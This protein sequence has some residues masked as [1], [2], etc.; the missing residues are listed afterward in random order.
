MIKPINLK[1]KP[2]LIAAII[3]IVCAIIYLFRLEAIGWYYWHAYKH[4]DAARNYSLDLQHYQ[5]EIDGVP[6]EALED[7]SGLTYNASR[8]SLFTVLNQEPLIIEVSVEGK[9]LRKIQVTGADDMEGIT[10][11]VD[12]RYVIA[13]EKDNRLVLV[14]IDDDATHVDLNDAPKL[15]LGINPSSNKNFEGVSWDGRNKRLLVTKERDPKYVMSVKGFF[16]ADIGEPLNIEISKVH[17]FDAAIKWSLR[18][19]S[20]LTYHDSSGHLFLLSDESRL[21]KEYDSKGRAVGALALWKGFHGLNRHVPQAEGIAVGSD[22]RIFVMS[23]PN[24]LYVFKPGNLA[25]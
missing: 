5:V 6:I 11:I 20:S 16:D 4:Q 2:I 14:T 1:S 21:I 10:H 25:H 7:A 19:L 12:N 24:L 15:K 17:E 3:V 23:E 9:I 18:D 13:D 22:G 8:N